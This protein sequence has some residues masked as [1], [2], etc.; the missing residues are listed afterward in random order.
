MPRWIKEKGSKIITLDDGGDGVFC[1][2]KDPRNGEGKADEGNT[3]K[4]K[5]FC[6][7][8]SATSLTQMTKQSCEPQAPPAAARCMMARRGIERGS[9]RC[10]QEATEQGRL[11]D[12]AERVHQDTECRQNRSSHEASW[13]K[14]DVASREWTQHEKC[15]RAEVGHKTTRRETSETSRCD[16]ENVDTFKQAKSHSAMDA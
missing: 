10:H 3:A 9:P 14:N 7:G 13:N 1:H 16:S 5:V 12:L 2:V 4:S 8:M 15:W 6:K 11:L